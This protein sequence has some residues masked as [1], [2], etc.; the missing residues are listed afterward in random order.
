MEDSRCTK[1]RYVSLQCTLLPSY[2]QTMVDWSWG[3]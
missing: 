1:Y 2:R 3:Q